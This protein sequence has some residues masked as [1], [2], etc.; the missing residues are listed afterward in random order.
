MSCRIVIIEDEALIALD[1]EQAISETGCT[2]VGKA[3]SLAD[4]LKLL[5]SLAYDSVVLDANLAGESA[6]PI[7]R[8]LEA[9]KTPFLIVSG[10]SRD[11]LG[12]LGDDTPLLGK[13][14]AFSDLAASITMH[15]VPGGGP[16]GT[17]ASL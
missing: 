2:V 7:A 6:E 5:D 13:P 1:L 16:E 4:G 11:Q 10:Y 3:H 17:R 15:L 14:F 9:S 12:F 8:R